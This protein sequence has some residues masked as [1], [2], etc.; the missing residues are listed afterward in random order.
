MTESATPAIQIVPDSGRTPDAP[1]CGPAARQINRRTAIAGT[2]SLLL[3]R[4]AVASMFENALFWQVTPP[5]RRGAVMFGYVR[6]AA[7]VVP[8][9]V[10]DGEALAAASQRIVTDMPPRV[11]FPAINLNGARPILPAL[12]PRLAGRLRK[13]FA[14]ALPAAAIDR[15]SAL[16]VN[17][18]LMAEG[19]HNQNGLP[20][21]GGRSLPSAG[22]TIV[23]YARSLGRPVDQLLSDADVR[24]AYR[25]LDLATWSSIAGADSIACLLDLR[26]RVGPVGGY[27]EEQYRRRNVEEIMRITANL[28]RHGVFDAARVMQT[29]RL[30]ELLLERAL[31]M[32]TQQA[33]ELRFMLFPL[34]ILAGRSGLLAAFASKGAVVAPRG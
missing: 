11:V 7:R 10:R 3:S 21:S 34:G 24:S 31:G 17:M 32:L 16:E 15:M 19:Q 4:H 1:P 13:L 23:D 9:I 33:D 20:G 29:G 14:A 18:L 2:A 28:H 22:G 6:I 5:G 25:P 27:L 26:D 30:R 12:S 8:D